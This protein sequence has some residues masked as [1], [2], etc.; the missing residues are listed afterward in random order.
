M[1]LLPYSAVEAVDEVVLIHCL[2]R[3][4]LAC[5]FIYGLRP[6]SLLSSHH[7]E[8]GVSKMYYKK[9]YKTTISM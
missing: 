5:W 3:V 1:S 8:W 9:N 2:P 6:W 7:L 4:G